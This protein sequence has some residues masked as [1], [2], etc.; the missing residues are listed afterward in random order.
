[1]TLPIRSFVEIPYLV[2]VVAMDVIARGKTYDC[3]MAVAAND[4][5]E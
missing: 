2:D 4:L 1:M 3:S 5:F